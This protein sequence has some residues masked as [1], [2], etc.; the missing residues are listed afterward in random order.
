MLIDWLSP[1]RDGRGDEVEVMMSFS[2]ATTTGVSGRS[3]TSLWAA[4]SA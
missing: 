3:L 4:A 2:A 1:P